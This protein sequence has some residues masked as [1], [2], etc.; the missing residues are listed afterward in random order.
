[1]DEESSAFCITMTAMWL[2][3]YERVQ[4]LHEFENATLSLSWMHRWW[5]RKI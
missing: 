1:L 2:Q 5:I 4:V 3:T